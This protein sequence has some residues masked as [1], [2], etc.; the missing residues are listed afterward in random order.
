M[1]NTSKIIL[2]IL[3]LI[4]IYLFT[5]LIMAKLSYKPTFDWWN[6]NGGDK[7]SRQFSIMNCMLSYYST[8]LY[9]ISKLLISP[10]EVLNM[11][12]IAFLV[13]NIFPYL[14]TEINGTTEGILIPRHICESVLLKSSDNDMLFNSWLSQSG[15]DE[16]SILSYP[17]FTT[18]TSTDSNGNK[19]TYLNFGD[20]LP[21]PTTGQ[22]GVYPS[23]SDTNGW[24]GLISD[25][26]GPG[27]KWQPD[28]SNR[29]Y[30]PEPLNSLADGSNLE[31]FNW[32]NTGSPRPDNF[33]ARMGIPPDSPLVVYFCTGKY[34]VNGIIADV[35]AFDNLLNGSGD[36]PGGWLGYIK[37]MGTNYSPD[38]YYN[39][40]YTKVDWLSKPSK[41]CNSSNSTLNTTSAVASTLIPGLLMCAPLGIPFGLIAGALVIG[42]AA[43]SGVKASQ[44]SNC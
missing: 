17:T 5:E 22:I 26:G 34:S 33:L 9:Y 6:G 40:I 18:S 32:N 1:N 41:P 23:P 16:A 12:Q 39:Y 3:G 11:S 24:M 31:W 4:I 7:Y 10:Q 38:Q 19:F 8:P 20:P 29:F 27:L 25:W 43:L 36:N 2:F 37:G 14:R 28:S 42:Q 35:V 44:A 30:S 15:K 21:D 13:G